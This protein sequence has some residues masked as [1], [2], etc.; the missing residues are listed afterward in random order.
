MH[1]YA[2]GPIDNWTGWLPEEE[3]LQ[4]EEP[5]YG[6]PNADDYHAFKKKAELRAAEAGWEG[7]IRNWRNGPFVAPLP[8]NYGDGTIRYMIAWK[9]DNNG[10]TFVASPFPLPW[11]E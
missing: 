8:V 11:L 2:L 5:E 6:R 1:V 4:L 9:Q 10:T 3:F 7:D